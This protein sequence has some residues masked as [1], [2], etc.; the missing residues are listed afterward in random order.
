[1]KKALLLVLCAALAQA[2][3]QSALVV[4]VEPGPAYSHKAKFGLVSLT[5]TPQ[6]A[7]WIEAADGSFVDTI[8]VT[9]RAARS[10]WFGGAKVRRPEALPLWSHARGI[11]AADGLY[12]P[13]RSHPLSDGISGATPKAAFAKTW[14]IPPSLPPG[15]YRVRVELNSSFDW[16]EAYPEKLPRSDPRW[17]E[18][19]GQPSILWEAL[20]EVGAAASKAALAPI[21]TGS[22][23]GESGAL[24]LGLAGITS[25][26]E[27]AASISAEFR[28]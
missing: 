28:P 23:R 8:F 1:M 26:R 19:N 17:S 27:L 22:L 16:N 2:W 4:T 10:S 21:G 5:V 9:A 18:F 7:I 20:I 13:D 11:A 3:A 6:T 12:M 25:A 15:K 24:T 14:R